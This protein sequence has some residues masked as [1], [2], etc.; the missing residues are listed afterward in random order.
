[1]LDARGGGRPGGAVMDGPPRDTLSDDFDW[2][3]LRSTSEA[4][5][6]PAAALAGDR[7]ES[8][9][10]FADV[11]PLPSAQLLAEARRLAKARRVRDRVF[12][13]TMFLNPAW[14]ILV[15]L[16]IAAEEGRSV[17]I[18]SACVAAGVPQSTALR[19]IAHL[20]EMRLTI[21]AQHPSDARSAYLKLTERGRSGMVAFLSLA[22]AGPDA[23]DA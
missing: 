8:G 5:A 2:D 15:E 19:H 9:D 11:R 10:P 22:A 21:R 1:M 23:P 4:V 12:D 16:F 7:S 14:N 6:D 13:R 3:R 20:I 18:K 17:T